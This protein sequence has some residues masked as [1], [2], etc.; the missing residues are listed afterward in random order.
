MQI[1]IYIYI[2]IYIK[3]HPS[4]HQIAAVNIFCLFLATLHGTRV[5]NLSTI[6]GTQAACL[7]RAQSYPLDDPLPL[8]TSLTVVIIFFE[9][10]DSFN[11]TFVTNNK[12]S[13]GHSSL[14]DDSHV[15]G[16]NVKVLECAPENLGVPWGSPWL[17]QSSLW[18]KW[19]TKCQN[20][21][22]FRGIDSP[23]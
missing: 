7:G 3:D 17:Q 6:A 22:H 2:Y 10:K 8:L 23:C 16:S 11:F 20:R 9:Y 12:L 14:G 5:L 15:T 4:P 18:K 21:S 13:I 19:K 1:N